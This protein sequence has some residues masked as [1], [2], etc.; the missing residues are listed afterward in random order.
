M[1]STIKLVE[2]LLTYSA[3]PALSGNGRYLVFNSSTPPDNPNDKQF[4]QGRMAE[5]IFR[6]DFQTGE[7]VR[8]SGN[9]PWCISDDAAISYDGNI[10]VYNSWEPKGNGDLMPQLMARNMN[11]GQITLVSGD[12]W[13]NKSDAGCFNPSISAD[14]RFV[15]FVSDAKNLVPGNYSGRGEVFVKDL[16]TGVLSRITNHPQGTFGPKISSDGRTVLYSTDDSKLIALNLASGVQKI[17]NQGQQGALLPVT[18]SAISGDGRH[19]V[20]DVDSG[21]D[22]NGLYYMNMDSGTLSTIHSFGSS[23]SLSHD[24]RYVSYTG[25]GKLYL[26]DM[27][28]GVVSVLNDTRAAKAQ[29]SDDGGQ[30][31][32]LQF[33]KPLY[34]SVFSVNL[35]GNTD[36]LLGTTDNDT[37][38]GTPGNDII[39]GF[40]GN[41]ML[42]GGAGNDIL[43]GGEGKN[44]LD[45]G[46]GIDTAVFD[47]RRDYFTVSKVGN[48]IKVNGASWVNS[49]NTLTGIE[50]LK[51]D[52]ACIA[53]DVDGNGGQ[54]YRLYR[55]AFDRMPDKGGL[56]FWIRALD[57]GVSF[58]SVAQDFLHSPEFAR[59]YGTQLNNHEILTK[60]YNNVLHRAPDAGG[61]KFW[62]DALD[63]GVSRS[64]VLAE[65]SESPENKAALIGV[66][67]QG[68]EYYQS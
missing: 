3:E 49:E 66:L 18:E 32:F 45:G 10:V 46:T 2:N 26:K 12:A 23:P 40:G 6:K 48:E 43:S 36:P 9:D 61:F 64:H 1:P 44:I 24:G 30:I 42:F 63:A 8:L 39:K 68:F 21:G 17:I 57:N 20:F 60:F 53:F 16:L 58:E 27:Q 35:S 62:L 14:G 5:F 67:Q 50:R 51:F 47:G 34:T 41:D 29:I 38:Y 37:I 4:W 25:Y 15:C 52:N 56:G 11:T 28:T 22:K 65:F 33:E 7:V 55:A 31:T 13:G 19:I 54:A 59:L